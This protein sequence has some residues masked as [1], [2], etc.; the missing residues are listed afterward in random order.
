ML[1][2]GQTGMS[3]VEALIILL[4][5]MLL[6]G[7]L[8]PNIYEFI[9]DSQFV[10]VKED[11]EAISIETAKLV[12]DVG[13]CLK[14]NAALG[15]TAYNQVK[16]MVSRGDYSRSDIDLATAPDYSGAPDGYWGSWNWSDPVAATLYADTMENQFTTNAPA[17]PLPSD[18]AFDTSSPIMGIGWRGAYLPSP[19][20]P[21][22]WGKPYFVNTHFLIRNIDFPGGWNYDVFCLSAGP[23][24]KYQTRYASIGVE[25][26][27]DD[28]VSLVSGSTR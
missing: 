6:T 16:Q 10:K 8:A 15:C 12:R 2:K 14:F 18:W 7:V 22:P 4:V 23:N 9:P 20:G 5:L 11:C 24:R 26:I 27:G 17:Y 19:I 13:P 25:T 28:F 21:D 3:L 1:S